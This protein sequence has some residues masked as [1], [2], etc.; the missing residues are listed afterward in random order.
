LQFHLPFYSLGRSNHLLQDYRGL[1]QVEDITFLS[2]P[3]S[4]SQSIE[5]PCYLY[6]TQVS[7]CI[8]GYDQFIWTAYLFIDRYYNKDE[9]EFP[10]I[11]VRG[12]WSDPFTACTTII[13][14]LARKPREYFLQVLK[15]WIHEVKKDWSIL[16]EK[17]Q[18][19][20]DNCVSDH[21]FD[22]TRTFHY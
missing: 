5:G 17:I 19:D 15:A 1:R 13:D 12:A 21:P 3:F 6:E 20:V 18:L 22:G 2:Q 9:D 8:S 4:D 7:C 16:V 10:D 14:N 11:D